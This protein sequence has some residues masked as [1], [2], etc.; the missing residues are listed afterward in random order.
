MTRKGKKQEF[1][2]EQEVVRTDV[3]VMSF[4]L[5]LRFSDTTSPPELFLDETTDVIL[6]GLIEQYGV[7]V[8]KINW[9]SKDLT[10]IA[11]N[12]IPNRNALQGTSEAL[13][14]TEESN[15]SPISTQEK[16][17]LLELPTE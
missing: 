2:I 10:V 15:P 12:D 7:I 3:P 14:S 16:E 1:T 5:V 4:D 13:Q 9:W 6:K 8:V 17:K 11:P